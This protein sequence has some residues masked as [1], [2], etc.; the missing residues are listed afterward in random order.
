[1]DGLGKP[2]NYGQDGGVTVRQG[3][4]SYKVHPDVTPRPS[5]DREGVQQTWWGFAVRFT[6][7]VRG[8][9]LYECNGIL[10]HGRPPKVLPEEGQGA[11][12]PRVTGEERGVYG[13]ISLNI[14]HKSA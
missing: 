10:G 9:G 7:S 8:A 13:E 14:L 11:L 3:Q 12:S 4:T 1:M 2:I 5:K 6:P